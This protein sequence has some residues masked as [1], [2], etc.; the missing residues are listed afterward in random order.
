MPNMA[1]EALAGDARRYGR[2]LRRGL[3]EGV[4]LADS[5]EDEGKRFLIF[6]NYTSN[7]TY[8]KAVS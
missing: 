8:V 5:A 7:D 1:A 2:A 3:R 6:L 4:R